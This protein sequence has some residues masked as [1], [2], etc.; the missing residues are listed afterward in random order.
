[1]AF[2]EVSEAVK[3]VDA[4]AG[5]L[6]S[7]DD[8]S[9]YTVEDCIVMR[10][11]VHEVER[12]IFETAES[13]GRAVSITLPLDP[14]ATAGAY[15]RDLAKRLSE[16]GFNVKLIRPEKGKIQRFL[17]FASVA[18]AGFVHVVKNSFTENYLNELESTEFSNKTYDDQADATS[19]AFWMLN[20]ELQ[21]PS[22][23]L[24]DLSTSQSFGYQQNTLSPKLSDS[25][26]EIVGLNNF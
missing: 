16:R 8:A 14:G 4:T 9:I 5:V 6:M 7:K 17:P 24:P 23:F 12:M 3:H 25:T 2:R 21:L 1:L 15:C 11:R 26:T 19:D 20:R 10:K 18:E 13:D 22:F